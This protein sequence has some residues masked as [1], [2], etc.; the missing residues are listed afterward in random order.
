MDT[1]EPQVL[2]FDIRGQ[3]CPST[4]LIALREINRHKIQLKEGLVRLIFKT[5]N[6]DCLVT[7]PDAAKNMGYSV[8]VVKND[9]H[10]AIGIAS[11]Q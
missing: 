11:L 8:E 9:E 2:E 6:R 3:I 5:N 1:F 4:L 7:I 10:Y